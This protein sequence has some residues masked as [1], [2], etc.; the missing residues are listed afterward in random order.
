MSSR[1]LL[2]CVVQCVGIP[3]TSFDE[4]CIVV[5]K[6]DKLP[7]AEFRRQLVDTLLNSE[8]G[9][10][11]D[12]VEMSVN[13]LLDCLATRSLPQLKY[14][15]T[16]LATAATPPLP[17]SVVQDGFNDCEQLLELLG[18]RGFNID[19]IGPDSIGDSIN[20]DGSGAST[21]SSWLE[22]DPS[23]VRGLAYY[24]GVVFEAFDRSKSLRAVCGG[25]R[26]DALASSLQH[27]T[28]TSGATSSDSSDSSDTL[29]ASTSIPA[30][31]FGFGD[32]VIFELLKDKNLLPVLPPARAL[33]AQVVVWSPSPPVVWSPSPPP[34]PKLCSASVNEELEEG[35]ILVRMLQGHALRIAATVREH[36][37]SSGVMSYGGVSVD[38]SPNS[39]NSATAN[40]ISLSA[41]SS[42]EV[43][44]AHSKQLKLM[45][46]R[47]NRNQSHIAIL[48]TVKD[49]QAEN[50][51]VVRNLRSNSQ[52]LW[53]Y[54]HVDD[55]F[56]EFLHEML[57]CDH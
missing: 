43:E 17:L 6:M 12:E 15:L 25:G 19:S 5:D 36:R 54:D 55:S 53:S 48:C 22:F 32:A 16:S 46:K 11:S 28:P 30:V 4:L 47:A 56:V 10:G 44:K 57:D 52:K 24:T 1:K 3:A 34:S 45:M 37:V 23:I 42:E 51:F 50:S 26:Y 21:V 31:G 29:T 27:G 41:P 14:K 33:A 8:G 35:Y 2:A 20:Q 39:W 7:A 13:Q 9:R 40:P 49:Y 18:P 38:C